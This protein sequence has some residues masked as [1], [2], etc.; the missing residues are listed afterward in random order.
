LNETMRQILSPEMHDGE[1]RLT[2]SD[3]LARSSAEHILY[4]V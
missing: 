2:L 4:S 3:L 1:L